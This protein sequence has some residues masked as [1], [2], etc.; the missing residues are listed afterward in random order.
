MLSDS[1]QTLNKVDVSLAIAEGT[2]MVTNEV[3]AWSTGENTK[4]QEEFETP[5]PSHFGPVL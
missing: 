4:A 5:E 3:R 2:D 1:E